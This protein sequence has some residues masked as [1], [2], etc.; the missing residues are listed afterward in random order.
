MDSKSSR[1]Q[2]LIAADGLHA[3][4]ALE[5]DSDLVEDCTIRLLQNPAVHV[6]L[7]AAALVFT[8]LSDLKEYPLFGIGVPCTVY[9]FLALYLVGPL[10]SVR[11]SCVVAV[12]V[13][14]SDIIM[15][16]AVRSEAEM[17]QLMNYVLRGLPAAVLLAVAVSAWLGTQHEA[18]IS[19]KGKLV[20]ASTFL[21]L[22]LCDSA[23][24]CARTG[25]ARF[26]TVP[27]VYWW[28]PFLSCML[29]TMGIV[30]ATTSAV[31]DKDANL[32]EDRTIRLL[33]NPAVHVLLIVAALAFTFLS[34]LKEYPLFGIGVPCTVYVFLALYLVGPLAS[35]RVSCVVAVLVP[36]S[37][38]IMNAAV[39]SEAEMLQLMNYVLRGLPAAV[40]L[41]V[42]VSA[43]LGTQHEAHISRKGKLV[44]ASTFLA[45]CLCDS[46]VLCA[47]TGDA[48]FITV[49]LVY[50]WLP[51]LSCMLITMVIVRATTGGAWGQLPVSLHPQK[52]PKLLTGEQTS[53]IHAQ[54]PCVN[55]SQTMAANS[56]H[57][58]SSLRHRPS[59]SGL[60]AQGGFATVQCTHCKAM[61]RIP[62]PVNM[63]ELRQQGIQCGECSARMTVIGCRMPRAASAPQEY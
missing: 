46:A 45:L 33:L 25:D 59:P 23:V 30:R 43:W 62:T 7:I 36:T 53:D 17:L 42:A 3:T 15:N 49:P 6:L 56:N 38:I 39:R 10:A 34:D 41:A 32:L 58:A 26:I 5:K 40:L 4:D 13:P 61:L 37:D 52:E 31:S 47:R 12:L 19:R 54:P 14:T 21:A 18:H 9:V 55:L 8:F 27:L 29:I 2:N 63:V 57:A 44:W 1:Q 24:L 51:F 11:V 50:W 60:T 20:W 28:L 35:V 16:A 48:R 22:C